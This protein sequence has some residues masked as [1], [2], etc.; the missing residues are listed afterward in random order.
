[1]VG[2]SGINA[3]FITD[4]FPELQVREKDKELVTGQIL[5]KTGLVPL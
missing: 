5:L 1:M 2:A 4:D 3:M